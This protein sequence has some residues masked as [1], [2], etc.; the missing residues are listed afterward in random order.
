MKMKTMT[1]LVV[2]G[3]VVGAALGA[4]AEPVKIGDTAPAISSSDTRGHTV[5]LEDYAGK[6]VV[7]E[8]TNPG[9]PFVKKH[10]GSGNMQEVQKKYT[11]QGVIWLTICSSAPGKQGHHS[12]EEWN[13]RIAKEGIACT[14]LLLDPEGAI[15]RAYG[16]VTTP[17]LFVIGKDGRVA[18]AGAIDDKPTT[19]AGD[20]PGS[21]NYVAA[22]MDEV[23]AGKPVTDP[24]TK[25][26]G[27]SVKY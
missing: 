14:A 8:W 26:Y 4:G 12:A 1:W 23:L 16:A 21:R 25:P 17:H 27:C 5:K 11:G 24:L 2:G 6:V 15:G 19:D 9:C 20:I 3:I 7:L 13:E 22:A 18:Y 10:Y